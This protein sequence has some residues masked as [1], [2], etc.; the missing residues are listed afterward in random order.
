MVTE[1]NTVFLLFHLKRHSPIMVFVSISF[2]MLI[3]S[4]IKAPARALSFQTYSVAPHVI[5]ATK[6]LTTNFRMSFEYDPTE[7]DNSE[8]EDKSMGSF[9]R[10]EMTKCIYL[11]SQLHVLQVRIISP[12]FLFVSID[13]VLFCV[14]NCLLIT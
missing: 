11:G 5:A 10:E 6:I 4:G 3:T 9:D 7:S 8:T 13:S 2:S 14:L 12:C 1:L